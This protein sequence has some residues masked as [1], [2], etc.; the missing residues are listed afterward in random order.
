MDSFSNGWGA[1]PVKDLKYA[2][3]KPP[4]SLDPWQPVV[5]KEVTNFMGDCHALFIGGVGAV[6]KN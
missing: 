6:D 4:Y 3:A 2:G 5:R 1:D